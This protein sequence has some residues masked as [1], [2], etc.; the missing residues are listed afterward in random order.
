MEEEE[1]MELEL[2]SSIV[3]I[4]APNLKVRNEGRKSLG[5]SALKTWIFALMRTLLLKLSESVFLL[6]PREAVCPC[7]RVS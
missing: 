7:E 2:R 5:V 4:P 6:I 3:Q 1:G